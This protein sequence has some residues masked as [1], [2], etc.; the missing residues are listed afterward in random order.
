[1]SQRNALAFERQCHP[2]LVS[3]SGSELLQGI[4][5]I[6]KQ[7]QDDVTMTIIY[8]TERNPQAGRPAARHLCRRRARPRGSR[9]P[10]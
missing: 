8:P 4:G 7:V 2:E 3:G 10:A 5:G 9:A 6:L 1:M